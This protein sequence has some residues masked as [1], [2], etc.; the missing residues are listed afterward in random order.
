MVDIPKDREFALDIT[1]GAIRSKNAGWKFLFPAGAG[2][3]IRE[4]SGELGWSYSTVER[5]VKIL[6]ALGHVS[7]KWNHQHQSYW[8]A[9]YWSEPRDTNGDTGQDDEVTEIPF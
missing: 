5:L 6:L 8:E 1:W 9:L 2:A 7:R 4:L 3:T